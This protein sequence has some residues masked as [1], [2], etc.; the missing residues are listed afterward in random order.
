[1]VGPP[2]R[3]GNSR[4]VIMSTST[5]SPLKTAPP[6]AWK[7][8]LRLAKSAGRPLERVLRIEAASGVLLI[9]MAALA[10]GWANSPWADSYG[11][12]WHTP[13]GIRVGDWVFERSLEWVVNDGLMVIF[14]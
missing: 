6:E 5:P 7:P 8:L 9:V 1:M 11:H 12:F 13:L 14:F 2:S 10:L 4:V 3:P